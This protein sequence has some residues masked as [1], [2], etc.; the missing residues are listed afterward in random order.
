VRL[1]V[2][3]EQ[4]Y[5]EDIN[6]KQVSI[7]KFKV[8]NES[9]IGYDT[10]MTGWLDDSIF[11]KLETRKI[12]K[13]WM[14]IE[15]SVPN[16]LLNHVFYFPL[17]T[18]NV[19]EVWVNNSMTFD[20]SS[21]KKDGV[22]WSTLQNAVPVSLNR[23]VNQIYFRVEI[24]DV[25]SVLSYKSGFKFKSYPE[26][27]LDIK[28]ILK[29]TSAFSGSAVFY[30]TI[31]FLYLLLYFLGMRESKFIWVS[32]FTIAL[33][34]L[35]ILL[36]SLVSGAGT[37]NPV[38]LILLFI[39]GLVTPIMFMLFINSFFNYK[40]P[41]ML[42]WLLIVF[43]ACILLAVL[44]NFF[45]DVDWL[46]ITIAIL[47]LTLYFLIFVLSLFYPVYVIIKALKDKKENSLIILIG[48]LA[49]LVLMIIALF[50]FF[51][52]KTTFYT[53]NTFFILSVVP[54]PLSI[55]ISLVR[56]YNS[57]NKNLK[58][59]LIKVE[60]L[61]AATLREQE[62]KQRILSSQNETLEQQVKERTLEITEQK[63]ILQEKN[64]E[65]LDSINY[66]RR[67]QQ[68][69]L[70]PIRSFAQ[71]LPNSFILFKPKDIVAGDFYW[72]LQKNNR[73]YF[74]AA[75]CTGHGVP[76]AMVSV[77]CN[78]ALNRSVNE[79]SCIEPAEILNQ[80]RKIIIEE[81]EKSDEDVKDGMDISFCLLEGNK[82]SWAGANNPL[83]ILKKD[84]NDILEIKPD[85][86]PIGKYMH[87]SDF[88]NH[89]IE[90]KSGDQLYI[91]SDGYQDQFGGEKGKK[92]KASQ[93]KKLIVESAQLD[94]HEQRKFL[95]SAFTDW[96]GNLEQIDDVC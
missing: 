52:S 19:T 93:L 92:F 6:E 86:Q 13:Y 57:D 44:F 1:R 35:L 96:K 29:T 30:I 50:E 74:A 90:L 53:S 7:Y 43:G 27:A 41:K 66:A 81:F 67:I 63:K 87:L 62:E 94:M 32:I 65:I 9:K 77:V 72:L 18:P 71:I 84:T 39:L 76:G 64:H 51:S 54:V 78:N 36:L 46:R 22:D 11:E 69:I 82:L 12:T 16:K 49:P 3:N 83:W 34:T 47:T 45:V 21:L 37:F 31:T 60:E 26:F 2:V 58:K 28:K 85:K 25:N 38:V 68:A 95:E 10:L 4:N 14:G 40:I 5:M 75:D 79:F 20:I 55:L 88:T 15:V 56:G 80:T 61:T 48:M 8:S 33:G 23:P 70:P 59:Q 24:T 42:K 73:I 89:T 91:F 17:P